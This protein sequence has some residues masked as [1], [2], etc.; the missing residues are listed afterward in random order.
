MLRL[1]NDKRRALLAAKAQV[2]EL[3]RPERERQK[4]ARAKARRKRGGDPPLTL[5]QRADAFL[6]RLATAQNTVKAN[7]MW[8]AA[9]QLRNDLDAKNPERLAEVEKAFTDKFTQLEDAEREG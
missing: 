3:E 7:A 8:N 1:D 6:R 4:I 9:T 2:R 5:D